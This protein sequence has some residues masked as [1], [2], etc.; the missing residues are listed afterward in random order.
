MISFKG[1]AQITVRRPD[2][3]IK[4]QQ[5]IDNQINDDFLSAVLDQFKSREASFTM[6]PQM[7]YCDLDNGFSTQIFPTGFG[8]IAGL[9]DQ[10]VKI[11]WSVYGLGVGGDSSV[12]TSATAV[13]LVSVNP[14]FG[15][16]E[17]VASAR[18]GEI[19]NNPM[20]QP[21]VDTIDVDYIFTISRGDPDITGNFLNKTANVIVGHDFDI[22]LYSATISNVDG[23]LQIKDG[24]EWQADNHAL[25]SD[26]QFSALDAAPTRIDYQFNDPDTGV[27]TSIYST[28]LTLA[29]FQSGD[30]VTVPTTFEIR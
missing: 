2:G 24:I 14:S 9:V 28:Q 5:T 22:S 21:Q 25:K 19:T 23:A 26:I 27:R 29:S 10:S 7:I 4:S 15:F 18:E 1:Q 3:S 11:T 8:T 16:F 12:M 6:V 13:N 30:D 17:H 20:I